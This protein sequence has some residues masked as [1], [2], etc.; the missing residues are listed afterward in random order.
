MAHSLPAD[1]LLTETGD[2]VCYLLPRPAFGPLRPTG[3]GLIF[4]ALFPIGI[5]AFVLS[6]LLGQARQAA[7]LE[8]LILFGFLLMPVALVAFG[9]LLGLVGGFLLIGRF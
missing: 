3:F 2:T 9:F 1:I 4:F 8:K 5:G 6:F 7:P